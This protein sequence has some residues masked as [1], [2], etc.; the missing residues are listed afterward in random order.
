MLLELMHAL[1]RAR[2]EW[3]LYLIAAE[4]GPLLQRAR[5]AGI[6]H[7]VLAFPRPLRRLGEHGREGGMM[8]WLGRAWSLLRGALATLGYVYKLRRRLD[9]L[10]PTV[11]HSNGVKMHLLT[12]LVRKCSRRRGALVWHLHD[13]LS[14]RRLTSRALKFLGRE[15]TMAMANSKSVATDAAK[16]FRP[17]RGIKV[18]YNAVDT[19]VF[20]PE[21]PRLD[22]DKCAGL[23]A[24][25]GATVRVG[26]L[27][28]FA[29]W[30]GHEI[31]L[32]A[33]AAI[34]PSVPIRFYIIG[35]SIYSTLGSQW[36]IEELRGI[37]DGLRLGDRIGFTGFVDDAAAAIRSLDVVVHAS[38]NPEPFGLVVAQAMG[39]G[40]ALITTGLGGAR[41]IIEPGVD[42]IA[43]EASDPIALAAAMDNLAAGSSVRE[44]LGNAGRAK[45]VAMFSSDVLAKNAV[46]FYESL[47]GR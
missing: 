9:Q 8:K 28:T 42:C 12:A 46:A 23:P 30:K 32:R 21:G 14:S 33:A 44:H 25:P 24:P 20:T 11:V 34:R 29:K 27:A 38:T 15:C 37:A 7:E 10:V 18:I 26:L 41:E 6:S 43:Y 36:S 4:E 40:R 45:A 2:P 13:Y 39:C 47:I 19:D 5:E 1:R 22:L 35:G 16:I 31:F 3:S 17:Q